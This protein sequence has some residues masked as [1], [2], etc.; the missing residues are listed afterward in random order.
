MKQFEFTTLK[1]FLAVADGGS[2]TTAADRCNIAIAAL[3]KRISDLEA[4]AGTRFFDRRARGMSLTPAGRA[5]LQHAREIV[6][7]VERMQSELLLYSRGIHG[8]LRIAATASAVAEFLPEELQSFSD[9][10]PEV[11]V[12]LS[13][14]TSQKVVEAVLDG[15]ADVGIFLEPFPGSG[16]ATFP[17]RRDELCVVLPRAHALSRRSRVSFADTL[18][19]DH[20]GT[21]T[22]SSLTQKLMAEGG[23]DYRVRIRVGSVDAACRMVHAGLGICIA[24]RL[25]VENYQQCFSI[26]LMPL[27]EPWAVRQMLVGARSKQGLSGAARAF[28]HRCIAAGEAERQLSRVTKDLSREAKHAGQSASYDALVPHHHTDRTDHTD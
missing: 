8:L 7:G 15:R 24:P 5:L 4:S 18:S 11:A 6:Y 13:E 22:Q 28:L 10:H 19:Y 21:Q 20:I 16:L 1:L 23:A 12:D 26:G 9:E 2:L 27:D 14:G 25:I 17:Y 3:S